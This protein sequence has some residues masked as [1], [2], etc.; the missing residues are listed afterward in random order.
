MQHSTLAYE[1]HASFTTVPS[2]AHIITCICYLNLPC[3][4]VRV[5]AF[6]THDPENRS[7]HPPSARWLRTCSYIGGLMARADMCSQESMRFINCST[8]KIPRTPKDDGDSPHVTSRIV[9]SSAFSQVHFGDE[10]P[11]IAMI[12]QAVL[13]Q[14][15]AMR[16][17]RARTLYRCVCA[18]RVRATI[19]WHISCTR[20]PPSDSKYRSELIMNPLVDVGPPG[21]GKGTQ[22]P[23]VKDEY[24]LCHLATGDMLRA[25]VA[26]KTD[27]GIKAKSLMDAGEL[28]RDRVGVSFSCGRQMFVSHGPHHRGFVILVAPAMFP[29][30]E[31]AM[32]CKKRQH[33]VRARVWCAVSSITYKRVW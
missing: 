30:A 1:H 13:V 31:I 23:K 8:L 4:S 3:L 17:R 24:C 22:A 29:R 26:A 32:D 16:R 12:Q 21:A 33:H 9:F 11:R 2:L 25:A 27:M 10:V 18:L 15:L 20:F 6:D 5:C 7:H 14:A 28:V 19:Q